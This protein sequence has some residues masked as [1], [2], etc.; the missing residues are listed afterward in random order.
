MNRKNLLLLLLLC[1]TSLLCMEETKVNVE[2]EKK[3]E[4]VSEKHEQIKPHR[5]INAFN[6]DARYIIL[7]NET[8]NTAFGISQKTNRDPALIIK[9]HDLIKDEPVQEL[10]TNE[11]ALI[12]TSFMNQSGPLVFLC[13]GILKKDELYELQKTCNNEEFSAPYGCQHK[14]FSCT[15]STEE[16][17][18]LHTYNT[19][20]GKITSLNYKAEDGDELN[21]C[22]TAANTATLDY[23]IIGIYNGNKKHQKII[24]FD[25]NNNRCHTMTQ[26]QTSY[27][28][29]LSP[30]GDSLLLSKTVRT[31]PRWLFDLYDI[32]SKQNPKLLKVIASPCCWFHQIENI[33]CDLK[34]LYDANGKKIAQL[35]QDED[36]TVVG[37]SKNHYALRHHSG[38]VTLFTRDGSIKPHILVSH[39]E[40]A[41]DDKV[42]ILEWEKETFLYDPIC[43]NTNILAVYKTLKK[44][45]ENKGFFQGFFGNCTI[46]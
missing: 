34:S 12:N 19:N 33:F 28:M 7:I 24:I 17:Y 21:D 22:I 29:S 3:E 5:F 39:Y 25:K 46:N 41:I 43:Y 31:E 15:I 26:D 2:E 6:D 13:K 11:Y 20:T 8:N 45:P 1:S 23:K 42:S 40:P 30:S 18:P 44:E 14:D 10:T 32:S 35:T 38:K 16:A 4:I 37:F 27:I 9:S 36:E